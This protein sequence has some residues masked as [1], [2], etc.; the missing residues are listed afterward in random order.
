MSNKRYFNRYGLVDDNA[1]LQAEETNRR[2]IRLTDRGRISRDYILPHI[3]KSKL[4]IFTLVDYG[5]LSP[6][7]RF[8]HTITRISAKLGSN[9]RLTLSG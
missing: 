2:W 4:N 1:G 5:L 9:G 3:G 7:L 6:C 8:T